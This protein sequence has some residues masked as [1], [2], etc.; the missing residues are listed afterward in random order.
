M[1]QDPVT[2]YMAQD[3]VSGYMAQDPVSGYMAQDK[4]QQQLNNLDQEDVS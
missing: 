2:G 1:A 4:P 3:P